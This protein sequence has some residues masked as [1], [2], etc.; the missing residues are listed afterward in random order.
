MERISEHIT[1]REATKSNTA[2][3]LNINNI[4]ND[5]QTGNMVAIAINIFEPLRKWVGGAIRIN[6]FYRSEKLNQAIGGSSRSQHCQ[7]RA[8][9]IDDNF[10]HKTNAEMFNYIKQNL[11][12]DQMIWEFGDDANPDWVHVSYVSKDQNRGRC[13]RAEKIDGK[14]QYREI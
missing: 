11:S 13:L 7:G 14:T 8:L 10:G 3:R 2:L 5:Y 9:D 12:Y 1:L 4:P 6:S